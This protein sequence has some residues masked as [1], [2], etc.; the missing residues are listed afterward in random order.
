LEGWLDEAEQSLLFYSIM[1]VL[2]FVLTEII[3]IAVSCKN[4][5]LQSLADDDVSQHQNSP[6]QPLRVSSVSRVL[7]FLDFSFPNCLLAFFFYE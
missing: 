4:T 5:M 7:S 3:P 1:L 6:Y 2:I